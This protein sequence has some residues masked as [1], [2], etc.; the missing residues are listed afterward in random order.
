M[1]FA[2]IRGDFRFFPSSLT[3]SAMTTFLLLSLSIFFPLMN[4]WPKR[5]LQS[6]ISFD[7]HY[8]ILMSTF[9]YLHVW[10]ISICPASAYFL[11]ISITTATA[12][13]AS[14]SYFVFSISFTASWVSK[15][16][17]YTG[18]HWT[19]PG[20]C[21]ISGISW[22]LFSVSLISQTFVLSFLVDRNTHAVIISLIYL[23]E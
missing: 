2:S 13:V 9:A 10:G 17:E 15:R 14:V 7:F 1:I 11:S 6:L 18:Q 4:S 5:A 22:R 20:N 21:N 8:S 23:H 3:P 19:V 16:E 12:T